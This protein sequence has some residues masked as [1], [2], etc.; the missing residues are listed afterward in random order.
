[1][2]IRGMD[3]EIVCLYDVEKLPIRTISGALEV[4]HSVVERVLR[5]HGLLPALDTGEVATRRRSRMID[6]FEAYIDRTLER[7]PLIP[8]SV[9]HRMVVKRGY[10]S[11]CLHRCRWLALP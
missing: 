11:A 2:T 5:E 3:P 6:P 8:A 1:M 10:V 7:Y 9:L 4:H